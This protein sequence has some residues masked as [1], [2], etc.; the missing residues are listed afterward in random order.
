[1]ATYV[2]FD[3]FIGMDNILDQRYSLGNDLNAFGGRFYNAAAPRNFYVGLTV[4]PVFRKT[5][6][7][8]QMN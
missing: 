5:N 2:P 8:G 1:L 7:Q 6:S 4:R 3:F